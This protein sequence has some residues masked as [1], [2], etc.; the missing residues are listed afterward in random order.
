MGRYDVGMSLLTLP[1]I[2][3]LD[4][5]F[6][7]LAT[8]RHKGYARCYNC[9]VYLFGGELF[10]KQKILDFGHIANIAKFKPRKVLPLY[11]MICVYSMYVWLTFTGYNGVMQVQYKQDDLNHT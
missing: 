3:V 8:R 7:I 11:A 1:S 2:T 9:T 6:N 4:V 5:L 10:A